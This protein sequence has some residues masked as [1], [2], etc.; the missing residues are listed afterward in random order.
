ME[1]DKN[2]E[3][4]SGMFDDIAPAYDALNHI[5]SLGIDKLWRRKVAKM[6]RKSEACEV[7]DVAT[8]TGDLAITIARNA[9]LSVVTGVDFSRGM[10]AVGL[11]KVEKMGCTDRVHLVYGDALNLEFDEASFDAVTIGFGVRNFSNLKLG[12]SEMCRVLKSGSQLYVIE[13]S[14]PKNV[15]VRWGYNLYFK[16]ILPFVGRFRSKNNFA[17]SYL[18]ESVSQFLSADEFCEV[19]KSVGFSSVKVVSLTFGVATLYVAKK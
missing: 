14:M 5:L 2:R 13:L 8:G 12:V 9:P 4:I 18:P 6:I 16:K 11:E 10:L 3:K 1:L 19:L 7:L 15:L 17:Y